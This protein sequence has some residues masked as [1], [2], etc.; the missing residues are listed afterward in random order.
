[1]NT[2]TT[3]KAETDMA[4]TTSA[5]GATGTSDKVSSELTRRSFL[6]GA[7]IG[8]AGLA[9]W[10]GIGCTSQPN[11]ADDG[12]AE[13]SDGSEP[14]S[15]TGGS[16]NPYGNSR[17][18]FR[19]DWLGEP[20]TVSDSEITQTLEA[21]IVVIGCGHSGSALTRRAAELGARVIAIEAQPEDAFA[22]FGSDIGHLNSQWQRSLGIPEADPTEY[23]EIVQ[24]L[25]ADRTQPDLLRQYATRSGEMFDWLLEALTPEQVAALQVCDWPVADGFV[26]KKGIMRAYPGTAKMNTDAINT[27]ILLKAQQA[28]AQEAGAQIQYETKALY[29]EKDGER[30]TGVVAQ[31][32][33]GAYLRVTG[34]KATVIAAGDFA[35]DGAMFT[36]LIQEAAEVN[37]GVELVGMGRDGSGI[38]MGLWAGA[39]MEPGPRAAMG[40]N[41]AGPSSPVAAASLWLNP[42]GERFCNEGY[43]HPFI[44][45]LQAA[46]QPFENLYAVFDSNWRTMLKNQLTGHGDPM[47]WDDAFC[48]TIE[49]QLAEALA[50]GAEGLEA[51]TLMSS[52][53]VYAAN[54]LDELAGHLSLD[55]AKMTA[56]VERYNQM[57][58]QG[59]DTDYAKTPSLLFPVDTPPFYAGVSKH[60]PGGRILVTLAGLFVD[61]THNCLNDNFEPIPGL[62][63]VGNSSGGRFPLQYSAPIHGA[64]LGMANTLG[65]VLGEQLAAG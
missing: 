42:V 60:E 41:V 9:A 47:F 63:A 24:L 21:D 51:G 10:G 15:S 34:S 14:P 19:S 8:A 58:A 1:M 25:S 2:G 16:G 53:S 57:C 64:S 13:G 12:A 3:S 48:D 18:A 39:K 27:T 56:S 50:A 46:R 55:P 17:F 61:G 32:A 7:T 28:K 65:Y 5:S 6:V 29:L 49:P 23:M 54:S 37:P 45:G 22:A 59:K 26:W 36:A 38:R 4:D 30:V 31:D 35:S 33:D 11:E 62:Y 43:G 52:F 44:A 20:Q 40:A